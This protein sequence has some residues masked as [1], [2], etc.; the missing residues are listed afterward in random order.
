MIFRAAHTL[1]GNSAMLG[2]MDISGLAHKM[3]N[4]LDG[5]RQGKLEIT[6]EIMDILF[7]ALDGLEAMVDSASKGS[8]PVD[9]S[10][11]SKRLEKIDP[12]ENGKKPKASVKK[13]S[14]EK[15]G[16][17]AKTF[18]IKVDLSENA[19]LKSVR[20][21]MILKNLETLGDIIESVPDPQSIEGVDFEGTF[22]IHLGTGATP[23]EIASELKKVGDVENF[24]IEPEGTGQE[25]KPSPPLI[26]EVK[27]I[28][29]GTDTLDELVNLVGELVI[30]KS[31]FSQLAKD[32][33]S[34]HLHKSVKNLDRLSKELQDL[35]MSM[36]TVTV[37]HIFDKFPR[38]VRDL[39]KKEGKG[40]EIILEGKDIEL[41][42]TVLDRL[43]DPLV[44]LIRNCVD[45]GIESPE[46]REKAGKSPKGTIK[47]SARRVRDHVEIVIEDDG[48]GLDQDVIREAALKKGFLTPE[49]AD[50][51]GDED[52]LNLIF[53]PGFSGAEKVTDVS[54]RGVGMDVVKTTI[55]KLRGT[56]HTK[57]E[58]GKG[59]TFTLMLPLSLAI[60][61]AL[62]VKS[63]SDIYAIPT[64]DVVE[65]LNLEEFKIKKLKGKEAII[66][67]GDPLPILRLE[68]ILGSKNG[69]T[70]R[71]TKFI[72][73]E[74]GRKR[75][76]LAVSEILRQE[77]IVI[78]P[79]EVGFSDVL[80][81]S[82]STILG[83]GKVALILDV[84]N[85]A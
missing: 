20:A 45:H 40:I 80:G 51:M 31:R 16:S 29:V 73:F 44:H 59:T 18:K 72:V 81:I 70:H 71:A 21:F 9:C 24:E 32:S 19:A 6:G 36:R 10:E 46:E 83:D 74:G 8:L 17:S 27:S 11:I 58:K 54:G 13:K 67:R 14:K 5:V 61:K 3:E 82:G 23:E 26:K 38:M 63:K 22:E 57:S 4:V 62:L 84:H 41:D 34:I 76:G 75:L 79:L 69:N 85:L 39:A 2:F 50:K 7:E 66:H 55:S 49:E 65:V 77:E 30:N 43:G 12:T 25:C 68:R 52:L 28:R 60:I 78:K 48:A 42:R 35:S 47:L 53:R 37:A 64:R 15:P 56:I 33:E 1:K